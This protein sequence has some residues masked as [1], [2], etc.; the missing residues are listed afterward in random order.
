LEKGPFLDIRATSLNSYALEYL[1]YGCS[2]LNEIKLGYTG[3]WSFGE[4]QLWVNGVPSSGTFYY[5]GSYTARGTSEI[6][7]GWTITRF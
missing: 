5:N 6:P 7:S 3:N 4:F 2:K 1:F